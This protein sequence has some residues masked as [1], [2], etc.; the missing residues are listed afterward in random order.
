VR[1][2]ARIPLGAIIILAGA[3]ALGGC[4]NKGLHRIQSSGPGPDEFLI[5]PNKPLTAPKDYD[6]L[7]APTPGGSNLVDQDPMADAVVALGGKASALDAQGVPASD[8]A[9]V[10]QASRYGVPANTRTSLAEADAKFRKRQGRLTSVRLF[11]V[12]RYE[13]AYRRQAL[14][15]FSETWRFR[16]AGIATPTSPPKNE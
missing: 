7:P 4:S 8:G 3:M 1:V 2:T 12:D 9:L 13:Q 15:P 10:A 6:V 16:N 14:D 5:L 11:S